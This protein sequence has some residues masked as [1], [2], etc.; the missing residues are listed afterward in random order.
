M[1][2]L[3]Q[4][5]LRVKESPQR[6]ENLR[7]LRRKAGLPF[8]RSRRGDSFTHYEADAIRAANPGPF[9]DSAGEIRRSRDLDWAE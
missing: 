4:S 5:L 9:P 2:L 6:H 7:N 8:H 1:S 3:V